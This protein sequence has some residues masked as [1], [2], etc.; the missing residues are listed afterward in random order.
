LPHLSLLTYCCRQTKTALTTAGKS[1]RGGGSREGGAGRGGRMGSV[2]FSSPSPWP[3]TSLIPPAPTAAPPDRSLTP[4][5]SPAAK[6]MQAA[7]GVLTLAVDV[8]TLA[9]SWLAAPQEGGR[10]GGGACWQ[11]RSGQPGGRA[12]G[13][14]ARP[15]AGVW[16]GSSP[17]DPHPAPGTQPFCAGAGGGRISGHPA[18]HPAAGSA[19]G[20]GLPAGAAACPGPT[21]ARDGS[22]GQGGACCCRPWQRHTPSRTPSSRTG[23]LCSSSSSSRGGRGWRGV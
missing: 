22:Q 11:A 4:A 2:P 8:A 10:A 15:R 16:G 18:P 14:A 5:P 9:H 6:G 13:R 12:G 7:V 23:R 3:C 17:P 1:S 19:G 21:G 20:A